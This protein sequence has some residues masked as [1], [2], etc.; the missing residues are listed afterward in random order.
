MRLWHNSQQTNLRTSELSREYNLQ[1]LPDND[2]AAVYT[3]ASVVAEWL[4]GMSIEEAFEKYSVIDSR[5][6]AD[7]YER[8]APELT[9]VLRTVVRILE[10]S[11]SNVFD[12]VGED[13]ERLAD[14]L[15]YGLDEDA[16]LN[17]F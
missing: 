5:T 8:L 17:R 6:P 3:T 7:V 13:I 2:V 1:H 16:L 10:I 14:Q 15:Y 11:D 9:R 4:D 12:E